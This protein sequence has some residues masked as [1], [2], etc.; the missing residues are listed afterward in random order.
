MYLPVWDKTRYNKLYVVL[1]QWDK[2]FDNKLLDAL[3][4][5]YSAKRKTFGNVILITLTR[6][7]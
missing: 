5:E 4:N 2:N 6:L 3:L 1:Y 7:L